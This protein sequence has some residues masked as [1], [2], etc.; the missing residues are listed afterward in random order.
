MSHTNQPSPQHFKGVTFLV[1]RIKSQFAKKWRLSQPLGFFVW[2]LVRLGLNSGFRDCKANTLPLE[3]PQ[4]PDSVT[5]KCSRMFAI[6]Q[7]QEG[8][9]LQWMS[10]CP[11][12]RP[13]FFQG[14]LVSLLNCTGVSNTREILQTVQTKV[15]YIVTN[16]EILIND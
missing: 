15:K 13:T 9:F 4:V 12:Y 14:N 6:R 10:G 1:I 2:F 8:H 16:F 3:P 5:G 7:V 11:K